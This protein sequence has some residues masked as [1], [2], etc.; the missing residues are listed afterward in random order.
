MASTQA[1]TLAIVEA[2]T[3]CQTEIPERWIELQMAWSGKTFKVNIAESDRVYDLKTIVHDLTK[4]PCERQ[5]IV[6]L[7]KGKLPADQI[8]ISDLKL[9]SGKK[10][11]LIGTPEGEEIKDPSALGSLPDI[12]NDLDVDFTEKPAVAQKYQHDA[13]NIR[14]VQEATKNLQLNIIHPIRPGKKLLVLDIDYTILDTRPLTS[15]SLPPAELSNSVGVVHGTLSD[16]DQ[17]ASGNTFLVSYRNHNIT[18]STITLFR[19]QTSWIWLE[20]KLVELGMVGANRNYNISFVLD[21]TCMFTVFTEKDNQPWSH[22][23]KALQIIWNHFPQFNEKNTIHVDDLASLSRNFALN[24]RSGL[25]ISA[26]KNA[27]TA[28]SRAD[29]ELEK[30]GRYMVFIASLP[31][32]SA[33][34]HKNWKSVVRGLGGPPVNSTLADFKRGA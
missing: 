28:E 4:V 31:D 15:G 19:S 30:L 1:E 2:D 22:S 21:K 23:V 10:F 13:R 11:T 9:V 12:V 33:L 5:K 3:S 14:K 7:V 29:R 18:A 26:F 16:C 32:F 20:T 24:P 27:H 17:F 25:K 34:S 8:R 6:G